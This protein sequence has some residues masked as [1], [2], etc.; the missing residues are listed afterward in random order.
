[1]LP[2]FSKRRRRSVREERVGSLLHYNSINGLEAALNARS[3]VGQ[4]ASLLTENYRNR[5]LIRVN[6][7]ISWR[8]EA[9][10]RGWHGSARTRD[11]YPVQQKRILEFFR[12]FENSKI[13]LSL[14]L[15][16]LRLF[17]SSIS[18]P[19]FPPDLINKPKPE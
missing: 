8:E 1:M 16:L 18:R 6:T 4:F 13:S 12:V 7:V 5:N 19:I 3:F 2:C 9:T 17:L 15:S 11:S 14:S 10:V